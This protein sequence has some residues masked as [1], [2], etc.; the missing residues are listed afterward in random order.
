[1]P[2]A[3]GSL[4]NQH[5]M[6]RVK[7][8]R[9]AQQKRTGVVGKC[10]LLALSSACASPKA[11]APPIRPDRCRVGQA[12]SWNEQRVLLSRFVREAR[13]NMMLSMVASPGSSTPQK[14]GQAEAKDDRPTIHATLHTPRLTL[15]EAIVEDFAAAKHA[16]SEHS[17][18]SLWDTFVELRGFGVDW[19]SLP[20]AKIQLTDDF[21]RRYAA[22]YATRRHGVAALRVFFE[23]VFASAPLTLTLTLVHNDTR[24]VGRWGLSAG[25]LRDYG[26]L[27]RLQVVAPHYS[28]QLRQATRRALLLQDRQSL[29]ALRPKL[30][31]GLL[32]SAAEARRAV[33][34]LLRCSARGT[35]A[36]G[37]LST[38]A[39]TGNT[40]GS[41]QQPLDSLLRY[42]HRTAANPRRDES[43]RLGEE[44]A[45]TRRQTATADPPSGAR[46]ARCENRLNSLLTE[47]LLSRRWTVSCMPSLGDGARA[48]LSRRIGYALCGL[49]PRWVARQTTLKGSVATP[50]RLTAIEAGRR[51]LAVAARTLDE[52]WLYPALP[53]LLYR[54]NMKD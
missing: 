31:C 24:L 23:P 5:P 4:S 33:D 48:A 19:R 22:L 38:G 43:R 8:S 20:L 18:R 47:R 53:P 54:A 51:V 45:E 52:G 15:V 49:R 41:S 27:E 16:T 42:L 11:N 46:I 17:K 44:C 28:R 14:P 3:R 12:L 39:E 37:G 6:H 21:G 10:C 7:R 2:N 25:L 1:M 29:M 35:S 34:A 13:A 32:K 30:A 36:Q 50:P 9:L 40:L 26:R